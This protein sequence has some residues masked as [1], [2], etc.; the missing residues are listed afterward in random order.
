VPIVVAAPKAGYKYRLY[1]YTVFVLAGQALLNRDDVFSFA[2]ISGKSRKHYD[3]R[4]F[5]NT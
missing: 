4:A 2:V 5:T 1:M 3:F